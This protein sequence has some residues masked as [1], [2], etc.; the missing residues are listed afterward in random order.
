MKKLLL[1]TSLATAFAFQTVKAQEQ[2][3]NSLAQPEKKHVLTISPFG[4]YN[5]VKIKY[6]RVLT[7]RYTSGASL[8]QYYGVYPGTQF[9]AFSRLYFAQE[10]PSGLYGQA[11]V[12]VYHHKYDT[13]YTRPE[14]KNSFT[15][16]GAGLGLGYQWL[17]GKKKNIVVDIMGGFK[18][19][20]MPE[21]KEEIAVEDEV[22]E[23]LSWYTTGPGSYF[24]GTIAVGYAF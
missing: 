8:A 5:K 17:S 23:A 22:V 15:S 6:E 18:L 13:D 14:L 16:G 11:Q 20:G 3:N 19:Y 10:A 4:L 9:T 12:A 21:R 24:N 1:L 2:T 7:G